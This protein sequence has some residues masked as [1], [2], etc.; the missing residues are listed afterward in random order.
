MEKPAPPGP[1]PATGPATKKRKTAATW[2]ATGLGAKAQ[3]DAYL[4]TFV[5]AYMKKTP[6]AATPRGTMTVSSGNETVVRWICTDCKE[7]GAAGAQKG[8]NL[9]GPNAKGFGNLG[10]HLGTETHKVNSECSSRTR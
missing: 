7:G 4:A 8:V 2:T 1:S 5:S 9:R 10:S 6:N 3:A